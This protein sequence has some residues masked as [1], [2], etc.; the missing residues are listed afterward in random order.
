MNSTGDIT[1]LTFGA[2]DASFAPTNPSG[3]RRAK[4][5]F[6]HF[7]LMCLWTWKSKK[8]VGTSKDVH[9]A[10]LISFTLCCDEG[11]WLR[12]LLIELG[13]TFGLER[14]K[15]EA[16]KSYD[17]SNVHVVHLAALKLTQPEKQ[18]LFDES[19]GRVFSTEAVQTARLYLM[20]DAPIANKLMMTITAKPEDQLSPIDQDHPTREVMYHLKE[21]VLRSAE[22]TIDGT[23]RRFTTERDWNTDL[24][25]L[26]P[27]PM[28]TDSKSVSH[29]VRNPVTS[30][31]S[32][33]LDVRWF[34]IREYIKEGLIRVSHIFTAQNVADFFTK[35]LERKTFLRMRRFL[36]NC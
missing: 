16:D 36:M 15:D 20:N 27:S 4:G 23:R 33:F 26:P 13:F 11:L 18:F 1:D 22:K 10:E 5:G 3:D 7:L 17:T 24:Y 12:R 34:R 9:S 8:H 29:T 6:A 30:S 21:C 19:G 14:I 31:K 35:A 25:H 32:R 2:G 28:L